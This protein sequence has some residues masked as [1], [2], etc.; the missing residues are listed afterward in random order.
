MKEWDELSLDELDTLLKNKENTIK[1]L[2][3]Y[4]MQREPEHKQVSMYNSMI[5]DYVDIDEDICDIFAILWKNNIMTI[6]SCQSNYG[7]K[8]WIEFEFDSYISLIKENYLNIRK[9]K[10]SV[11]EFVCDNCDI[12]LSNDYSTD[13]YDNLVDDNIDDTYWCSVSIRFYKS[14]KN[15]FIEALKCAFDE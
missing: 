10:P 5:D 3:Q 15:E 12:K 1:N 13:D 4:I 6:N 2:K 7:N 11:Y 8:I 14:L 9:E